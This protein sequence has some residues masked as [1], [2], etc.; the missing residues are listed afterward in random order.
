MT[1]PRPSRLWPALALGAAL[2][3]GCAA[4][5]LEGTFSLEHP[6]QSAARPG[7]ALPA[8]ERG[9]EHLISEL[10]WRELWMA[11]TFGGEA[12]GYSHLRLEPQGGG[13][14]LARTEE[15]LRLDYMGGAKEMSL[16]CA[17]TVGPDLSLRAIDQELVIDGSPVRARGEVVEGALRVEITQAGRTSREVFPLGGR[18]VYSA[19]AA[20]ALAWLWGLRVGSEHRCQV[21]DAHERRLLECRERVVALER[22]GGPESEGLFAGEA[23]RVES[24]CAGMKST[25]WISPEGVPL[26]VRAMGALLARRVDEA[27]A[28]AA[29]I[30]ARGSRHDAFFEFSRVACSDI[31]CR[32]IAYLKLEVEG[33]PAGYRA[34]ADGRQAVEARPGEAGR[35]VVTFTIDSQAKPQPAPE[36]EQSRS[37]AA[38]PYVESAEPQVVRTAREVVGQAEGREAVLRVVRWVNTALVPSVKDRVS[39]LDALRSGTGD[40]QAHA[41]LCAALLRAAGVPCKVVSGLCYSAA[42]RGFLYHTW[43]EAYA[44][45]WLAVDAVVGGLADA[46]HVKLVEGED[47][48]SVAPLTDIIGR[49]KA[50][51]LE[52]RCLEGGRR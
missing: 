44:G 36:A 17:D 46:G 10:P 38:S 34:P 42:E 3:A 11:V 9:P 22:A 5:E 12:I 47:L 26:A 49:I 45:G 29:L 41:Y 7:R 19:A 32:D 30:E 1:P 21:F 48:E 35:Q 4:S 13:L 27:T 51:V 28:R 37:L 8:S 2:L 20:D 15:V 25:A 39:A 14:F 33:L 23:A 6:R 24:E 40:C 50:K 16:R 52:Y 43:C 31:P 18:P